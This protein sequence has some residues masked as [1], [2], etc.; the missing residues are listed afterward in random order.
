MVLGLGGHAG[1]ELRD[2]LF[3]V[4]LTAK[5][6]GIK[7]H[8]VDGPLNGFKDAVDGFTLDDNCCVL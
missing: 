7:F 6:G 8:D 3:V 4:A 2:D 1:K 5:Y